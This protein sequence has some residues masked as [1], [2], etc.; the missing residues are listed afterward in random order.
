MHP[1]TLADWLDHQQ[2]Q[3]PQAIALGLERVHRV[4]SRLGI[5]RPAR[6]VVSIAG[7]NGKGSCVAM[8]DAMLRAGGQH[9][10]AYT[11]P[12]LLRYNERIR[13]DGVEADD[14]DLVAAFSAIEDAR[15]DTPLTYFEYGTLAALALFA[16]A[17]LDVALLE[18]GLGGRLDAVNIIDADVALITP[19]ALDHQDW[20]GADREAIGREKAGIVRAGRPVVVADPDPPASLLEVA[21][22]LGADLWRA[23]RD[24]RFRAWKDGFAWQG[25]ALPEAVFPRPPLAAPAQIGNAAASL[26]V[27]EA[28][29][30]RDLIADGSAARGL[31]ATR[32][33]GRL[34]VLAHAPEVIVD[35]AHNPHAATQLAEWLARVSHNPPAAD[36]DT[37]SVARALS[38]AQSCSADSTRAGLPALPVRRSASNPS[39]G[40]D[41]STG[42][43]QA[44]VSTTPSPVL[45][46]SSC[47]PPFGPPTAFVRAPAR[48][49]SPRH[50]PQRRL[51]ALATDGCEERELAT[52]P[53]RRSVAVFGALDDKDAAAMVAVLA[54]H[55]DEWHIAGLHRLSPRGLPAAA[56]FNRCREALRGSVAALH[57]DP[58][59]ALK[60][61]RDAAGP[62]GRVL[63]FG[64]FITVEAV[65][66]AIGMTAL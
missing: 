13:I 52:P 56:L 32:I 8:L 29:G 4:A 61:A 50:A 57:P 16:A 6:R 11:S 40:L 31:M 53:T 46:Q 35:V 10:G 64:S 45:R 21:D 20:L 59:A 9:V 43:G 42:S 47:L 3:H 2:R 15:G 48:T 27:L 65:M 44:K 24:Y 62:D 49:V 55:I 18:V 28:L 66:R 58:A 19:I 17:D 37:L 38:A 1:A 12:H 51:D 60:A 36:A 54:P 14:A 33:A 39:A 26:A 7:T 5:G 41:P 23:G 25:R 34:Q 22:Q 30:E 63:A